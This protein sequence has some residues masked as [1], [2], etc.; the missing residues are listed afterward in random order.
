[1]YHELHFDVL[2]SSYLDP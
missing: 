1:M 2:K